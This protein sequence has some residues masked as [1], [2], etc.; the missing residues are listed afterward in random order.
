MGTEA[1]G[2][3]DDCLLEVRSISKSFPG[4]TA[5]EGVS[6][7]VGRGTVHAVI[8]ENGAGKSTLMNIIA[9]IVPADAGELRFAGRTLRPG[10]PRAALESGVAMIH[11]ELNLMPSMSVAENIWIGREPTNA[12]GLIDHRE[13]YRRTAALLARLRM[14]LD[15]HAVVRTLPIPARQLVEI[16]R[17]LS[18]ESQLL[19]MDEPTSAL[20]HQDT[21]RL[22]A[23]IRELKSQ[24]K[25]VLYITH[26]LDELGELADEVTVLRDGRGLGTHRPGNLTREQ[27]IR[28]MVGRELT[29]TFPHAPAAHGPVLLAVRGLTLLPHFRDVS[30]ELH[31]GEILGVAGL[32]GAGRSALAESLFGVRP[33]SRGSIRIEGTELSIDTPC[34]AVARGLA[35]LTEDR[36]ETGC[37]LSLS[38]LENLEIAAL[39]R[40]FVRSGFVRR[41]AVTKACAEL[42]R[43]VGIKTPSLQ[44]PMAHLSGG[45]QQKV[46]L[47]RW[48]LT[49]PRILILDEPTRG[50]DVGA[51]AEIYELI[52][53]LAA[54]GAAVL[55]ISSELPEI[56]GL[57]HR[58]LV[59]RQGR[60]TDVL[61]RAHADQ[62]KIMALAAN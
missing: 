25:A 30:F 43:Q 27:M 53:R 16:A 41:A 51:R 34:T 44:E 37:L 35:F 24:G 17:A 26:R 10:S 55:M 31:A 46:L 62:E 38:V 3:H 15:A 32:I 8:G 20:S 9:G 54:Q 21:A 13:L 39:N 28:M 11:Q 1:A 36:R 48:L 23:I 33:A 40:S 57:S 52:A 5:L 6:L 45:N 4:V 14:D 18:Y 50:I 7:R 12:L 58:I 59:M 56:L 60:V 22:F 2:T 29:R 19:I 47:A 49:R 42:S 61:E